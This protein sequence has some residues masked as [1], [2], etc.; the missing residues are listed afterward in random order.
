MNAPLSLSSMPSLSEIFRIFLS[1]K[2]L[3]RM[4]EPTYWTE[5]EQNEEHY[6]EL[7]KA[8]GYE[9]RIDGRGFAWF[10]TNEALSAT[11]KTSRELA[12]LMMVIFDVQA[13]EGIPL[14]RFVDW[15][16]T[17][18]WL[19][20]AYAHHQ[21]VLDA[22]GLNPERISELM[23]RAGV[24]GFIKTEPQG[25]RLLPAVYRYLDHFE[26]LAAISKDNENTD[27]EWVEPAL[28]E[29]VSDDEEGV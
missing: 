7:F 17:R 12:L 9:L 15:L 2:H 23:N 14:H 25:W 24:L 8:L 20:E 27:E 10:Q 22:E 5:L 13:N 1:G 18:K 26:A 6:T 29:E 4:A 11:S 28:M 21:E 19:T 16:L 3:N